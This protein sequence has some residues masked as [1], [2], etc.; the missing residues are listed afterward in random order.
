M[1]EGPRVALGQFADAT[2]PMLRFAAQLGVGGVSVNTPPLP[3][4]RRWERD[5]LQALRGRC[6][7]FGLA[8]ESIENVPEHF[9]RRAMLGLEGAEDDIADV[10]ATVRNVGAAGIPVLGLHFLPG[11]VWRTSNDGRGRA[12]ATVSAFDGALLDRSGNGSALVARR[13][14]HL[15]DPFVADAAAVGAHP[16]DQDALWESFARFIGPVARAAED[17]GVRIALHP[18]DPPVPELA[19]VAR[20]LRDLDGL[21]RALDL[22]GS[23][24]V[25][26]NLCLGT[27]SA[28]GGEEAVLEAID[29]FGRRG[30]IVYVH[31]R[32]VKGTV[33]CFEECFL[34]EGNCD[35]LTVMRALVSAG[36]DGFMLDDHAPRL[37]G[38]PRTRTAGAPTP[39]ATCR[40]C[41]PR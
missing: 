31:F 14:Q 27:V 28:M 36:F 13:E 32:D 38:T 37:E 35:P 19:G 7:A 18:D 17:A 11:A 20:I 25:G 10:A 3:G 33:P 40:R 23:P 22:A 2:E 5:D 26:L 21:E 8:L 30:A 24:A 4:E 16:V 6:E 15:D 9:Y 34:G 29:R 12:G 39:S 1:P 41:S